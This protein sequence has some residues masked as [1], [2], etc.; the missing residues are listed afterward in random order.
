MPKL[1]L[2]RLCYSK[3]GRFED[4]QARP[5][6]PGMIVLTML[7]C[8]LQSVGPSFR[9]ACV[10]EDMTARGTLQALMLSV[11]ESY[12][13]DGEWQSYPRRDLRRGTLQGRFVNTK[14]GN[15][16]VECALMRFASPVHSSTLRYHIALHTLTG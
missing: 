6:S 8:S 5:S 13:K 12:S 9:N 10:A 2:T 7:L 14:E 15:P 11:D 3:L 1:W 4:R 16:C